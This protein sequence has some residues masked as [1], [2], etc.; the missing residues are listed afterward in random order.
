MSLSQEGLKLSVVRI[1]VGEA[2]LKI[3][4]FLNYKLL[5]NL[6]YESKSKQRMRALLLQLS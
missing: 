6:D 4:A 1:I 2:T 3:V 5:V